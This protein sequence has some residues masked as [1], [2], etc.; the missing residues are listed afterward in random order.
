M[1]YTDA[2][3]GETEI[4]EPVLCALMESEAMARMRRVYQ[5]GITAL[6]GI[7]APFSRFD[8]SVG[9]MLLV[10]RL[11]AGLEE[12][13]A[14]LLH[15]VSHTAFSH[16]IDYVYDNH[17]E[18]GYHEQKKEEIVA[19][20]AIPEILQQYGLDWRNFM[21]EARFPLLEQAAPALCADRLDY[22]LRDLVFLD[23]ADDAG[24]CAVLAALAVVN[25]QMALCDL[26]V[27]RWLAYT[28][29]EADHANWSDFR[30][31]GLY[32]VTAEAIKAA[33]RL[34]LITE[35]DLWHGDAALWDK[36]RKAE[37]PE[38][39]RWV[40]LVSPGTRFTWDAAHPVFR[41][42]PKIRW[43]D[44]P[45]L[46]EGALRPLS[47]LDPAF[48]AQRDRYLAAKQGPWPMGIVSVDGMPA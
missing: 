40:R 24:I 45:V 3:Y 11:G 19:R 18:Q 44:P 9:A 39:Q 4:A 14:T 36:L 10:R 46:H 29:I 43:I 17:G 27:A 6:L 25:G 21:D 38:V 33:D 8:H 34:G 7:S 23:L 47:A 22:F 28:Y 15:D 31:V 12:Q 1:Q 42:S 35:A 2:L 20:S 26:N 48:A 37:H 32:Q 16:V 30:E 13:I 41:V 5:H